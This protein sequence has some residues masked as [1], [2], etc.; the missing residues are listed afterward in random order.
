VPDLHP[1]PQLARRRWVDLG[2]TWRF[3]YDDGDVGRDEGWPDRTDVFDRRIE[4][5]YPP[6][7]PASGVG[8]T[9]HHPVVWYR[10]TFRA[11]QA[12]GERLL[13]RF[14]AVDYRASVWVNGAHA[15]DHEGGHTPFEADV[16]ALLTGGGDQVVVVRA[17]DRPAD[18]TQPRGKQDWLQTP[19]SIWYERTTGIWQT[20]WLEPVPAAR[21]TALRWTPELDRRRL[22][23]AVSVTPAAVGG[24]VRVRLTLRGE[25]VADLSA[26]LT[27]PEV[28][29]AVGLDAG[30]LAHDRAAYLWSPD[31][32][33]LLDATVTVEVG[34]EVVDTVDSYA[35]LRSVAV[36]GGRLLLN[37]RPLVLRMV[38]AQNYWPDSHLAA[39]PD[40]LRREVELAKEL[41][42]TGVRVHQKVEDPRFLHWCD[43]L[44][45]A[46]WTEMP[47]AYEPG[48]ASFGR[49][50]REWTDVVRRDWSSPAVLAWVP[51]NESWGVPQLATDEAQRHA[52]R[53]LYSATKALD[54]TRP[55]VGND[56]WEHVASDILGVHDYS[57][58]ADTLR[59]RYGSAEALER[60]LRRVQPYYRAL[61]L[62]GFEPGEEPLMVT[63]LGGVTYRPDSDDFWNGYGAVASPAELADRYAELVTA[64]LDSPVVAGWCWTQLTDT[65]QERNGLLYA[66]R[67]PKVDPAV[68]AAVTRRPAASVPADAIAGIQVA[69]AARRSPG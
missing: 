9:G 68:I 6:E 48:P 44:G 56:G 27:G 43:R 51:F 5:P 57:Q 41:G 59:E 64:L 26:A 37:D 16:T 69:H 29:L 22:A 39:T 49:L 60:T 63:E 13:L 58:S 25:L 45:L 14:G 46:V 20:V 54:P 19:H 21:V 65:G 12:P 36:S 8:E 62:P 53:A 32:P 7:S 3:A 2:G 67:T 38:L 35:G 17:E 30:R 10:R 24:R 42:F 52:V 1:T 55:V 18:L 33:N 4:V 31:H 40:Q 15:V 23:V 28:E 61:L 34:G 66:D 11:E 50:L 47:S